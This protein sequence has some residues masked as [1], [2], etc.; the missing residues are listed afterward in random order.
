MDR[1]KLSKEIV[2][3][4]KIYSE[5]KV[6]ILAVT[7]AMGLGAGRIPK[8]NLWTAS[9]E[10]LAWKENIYGSCLNTEKILLSFKANDEFL[11]EMRTKIKKNSIV[12]LV[13]RKSENSFMLCD[14]LDYDNKDKELEGIL[15]EE[16]KPVVYKDEVFGEF[17]L[18]KSVDVYEKNINWCG[19]DIRISFDKYEE[20]EI[21]SALKAGH[22]LYKDK[23]KWMKRICE[24]ASEELLEL[25]NDSW[26]EDDEDEVTKEN[27]IAALELCDIVFDLEGDFTFWFY[28]GDLFWGHS[29]IVE[30]NVDGIL[31]SA[32]IAG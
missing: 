17:N 32:Y 5:K 2:E 29:I 3:F 18:N 4:E 26:L 10:I 1:L 16:L 23:E 7:A 11:E 21:K 25:K 14:V 31:H 15:K 8:E 22:A 30:G 20:N 6:E 13:V 19:Y 12:K 28:D 24:F 27:F 9:I